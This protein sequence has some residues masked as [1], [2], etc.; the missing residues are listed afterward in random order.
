MSHKWSGQS[1]TQIRINDDRHA[2]FIHASTC[3]TL[4]TDLVHMVEILKI[5]YGRSWKLRRK[6]WMNN[7]Q[8]IGLKI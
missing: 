7:G 6:S 4:C 5:A 3:I 1:T 8:E 2:A